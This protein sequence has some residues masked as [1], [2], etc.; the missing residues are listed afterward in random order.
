MATA[1]F[2]HYAISSMATPRVIFSEETSAIGWKLII[3]TT[4]GRGGRPVLKIALALRLKYALDKPK[5]E[6]KFGN[7]WWSSRVNAFAH[8]M[9]RSV[10]IIQPGLTCVLEWRKGPNAPGAASMSSSTAQDDAGPNAA[11]LVGRCRARTG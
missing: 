11:R 6:K 9:R 8:S 5:R 2:V 7:V 1:S 4:K 3:N 10:K